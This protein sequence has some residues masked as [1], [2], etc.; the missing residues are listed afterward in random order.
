MAS[1][2]RFSTA[3]AFAMP[4]PDALRL[5]LRGRGL[6]R[7]THLAAIFGNAVDLADDPDL[8]KLKQKLLKVLGSEVP[9]ETVL[10]EW[11]RALANFL[12]QVEAW[13]G[14]DVQRLVNVDPV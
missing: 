4:L 11:L 10:D 1:T 7:A 5:A 13:E 12:P 8:G 9:E 3:S 14:D 6:R 2:S